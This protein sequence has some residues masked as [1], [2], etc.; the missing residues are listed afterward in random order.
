MLI[1]FMVE[2]FLSFKDEIEFSMVAGESNEHPDHVTEI[3]DLRLLKTSVVFG[4]NQSGKTN[5]MKAMS[6]AQE[7]I[8]H[9][10]SRAKDFKLTPFLLDSENSGK[11][12]K[13]VFELQCGIAQSFE[14]QFTLDRHR[15]HSE[16]LH[17][18]LSERNR[19]MFERETDSQGHT[20]V[21]IGEVSVL[22]TNEEDHFD[23]IRNFPPNELFLTAANTEGNVGFSGDDNPDNRI[24]AN[25]F[26]R[27]ARLFIG[28]SSRT[29]V[30][31]GIH[32]ASPNRPEPRIAFLDIIYDWF[33]RTLVLV[34]PDSIPIQGVGLGIMRD[35]EFKDRLHEVLEFLDLGIDGVDLLPIDINADSDL[36]DE[37]K[38]YAKRNAQNIS[39]GSDEK[40]IF[41]H[42]GSEDYILV[43]ANHDF[44]ACR[45]V[46]LH[47]V[48][49]DGSR[50]P[51]DLSAES[52]GTRRLLELIP[53]L[54]GMHSSQSKHVFII[55]ELDRSIHAH[56]T[57]KVIELFLKHTGNRE[58]Q[59]I[60]TSHDTGLLDLDLLR[61]D[62]IWFVEKERTD[63]STLYSLEEFKLPEKMNIEKGYL[64]G[65]FGAIPVTSSLESLDWSLES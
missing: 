5:L 62:E 12:S 4:A 8:T 26:K 24:G 41:G 35:T 18:I 47:Q 16:S 50:I 30:S 36:S 59:L 2:N 17:E 55:D 11:P 46:T 49:D 28:R 19:M 29:T 54:L 23:F 61:R 27:D 3:R 6:F 44:A 20:S 13:F 56:L 39:K 9:G 40:A 45:L 53:T 14:Y 63:A 37:F 7:F 22:V 48:N 15:V 38:D 65:R 51:F 64:F 33:D 43:D 32:A 1:R 42:P 31:A 58:N 34:F 52:D 60:V 10:P 21:R 25:A 57:G